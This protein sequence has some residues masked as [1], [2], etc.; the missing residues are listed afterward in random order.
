MA[1]WT[2]YV[3]VVTGVAGM[4]M[5]FLGYR[6]S[7]DIKA[8]DLRLELRKGLADAHLTASTVSTLVD[9]ADRSRQSVLAATGR[10]QSGIRVAWEAS[11]ATDRTDIERLVTSLRDQ[12][13]DF[14]EM[15]AEALE[16]EI[17][18]VHRIKAALDSLASKYRD[19]L[20][21]D[22]RERARLQ[23]EAAARVNAP[24]G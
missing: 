7:N 9:S 12:T 10:Y 3:G 19:E 18:A 15:P 21:K 22:D 5:G 2:G 23:Q 16:A 20:A 11:V 1:D 13:A 6:R 8:L 14:T 4:V 17:V 24:R